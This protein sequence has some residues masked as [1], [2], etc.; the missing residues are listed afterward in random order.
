[1]WVVGSLAF[2][3]PAALIAIQCLSRR[4]VAVESAVSA[5]KTPAVDRGALH[6]PPNSLWPG[7]GVSNRFRS[8]QFQAL[9][10]VV[11]FLV[12]SAGL[13]L[14]S[15]SRVDDDDQVL[16]GAQQAGPFMIGLYGPEG[17]I[18]VGPA[19]FAI[20]V[21][22]W[23][24]RQ[25]LLDSEVTL[26]MR[27]ATDGSAKSRQIAA[28]HDSDNKLLFGAEVDLDSEGSR[29]LE[30]AVQH[31]LDREVTSFPISVVKPQA[32]SSW[33]W[34]SILILA[35]AT[36]LAGLYFVRHRTAKS[37]SPDISTS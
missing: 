33:P 27:N 9:S 34:L 13:V 28:S 3:L 10:F 17:D 4:S 16:R 18:P 25:L 20:L 32:D 8:A 22:D 14:L 15:R 36:L 23:G 31:G 30:L 6:E 5:S 26:L 12:A 24:S 7:L 19:S 2:L 29:L 11:L 21:Q 37:A 1:M 35:F